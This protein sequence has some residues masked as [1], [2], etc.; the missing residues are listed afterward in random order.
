M[1]VVVV[2]AGLAGLVAARDL[3]VDH[4]VTVLDKGRSVGGRLATRRIG[5]AVLDHG[6]Q[7]FT[8]RRGG[9]F[10]SQVD[11]W[12]DRRVAR[13]WCHG[14]DG[15]GDGY[16]RYCGATGMTALAKDLA[17]GLDVRCATMVF[18]IRPG[19]DAWHVIADDATMVVA[20]VVVLTCPVPQSWALLM[21]S[22]VDLPAALTQLE[23][24]RTIGLLAVLD[25]PSTVP[26]PGGVQL[27]PHDAGAPFAF[28]ADNQRKGIS[29]VPALTCH[30][31]VP[32]S[33]DR[34]DDPIDEISRELLDRARSWTGEARV[35]AS[36]VKKW[37]FATPTE[38]WPDTCCPL[39]GGIVLAGD[40]FAGP[41]VEGAFVSGRAAAA[42]ARAFV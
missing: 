28:I 22:G 5:D 2:G 13:I 33:H 24:E 18:T 8:V 6:A 26:A 9:D 25:R 34:W 30:A 21:E 12:L 11:E 38:P 10:R 31:T 15:D 29:P 27:D 20:D 39:P 3:A 35:V 14:F 42:A 41:K 32:F 37:R 16:P 7:F 1:R 36:Q 17:R 40:A 23:Y 19:A 4:D